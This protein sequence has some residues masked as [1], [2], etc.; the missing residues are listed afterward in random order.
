MMSSTAPVETSN[1]FEPIAGAPTPSGSSMDMPSEQLIKRQNKKK[2]L[3]SEFKM[4]CKCGCKEE[5][6]HEGEVK[7]RMQEID[8]KFI[9]AERQA[10]IDRLAGRV[11]LLAKSDIVDLLYFPSTFM[12]ATMNYE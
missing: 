10:K 3:C 2:G 7:R 1:S 6:D 8:K 9:E 11:P 5:D 4:T 12:R